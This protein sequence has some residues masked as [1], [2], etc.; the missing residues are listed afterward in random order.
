MPAEANAARIVQAVNSHDALVEACRFVKGFLNRLEDG[1]T[2]DDP[3]YVMRRKVH[4]PLHEKLD[5]ALEAAKL[6][7]PKIREKGAVGEK[8]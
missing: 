7:P 8:P 5:I 4:A 2:E 1:S 6:Q 3:L